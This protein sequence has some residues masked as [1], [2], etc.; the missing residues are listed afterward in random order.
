MSGFVAAPPT[1]ERIGDLFGNAEPAKTLAV[2]DAGVAPES[3][4]E[5]RRVRRDGIQCLAP[6]AA[7]ARDQRTDINGDPIGARL[8][9]LFDRRPGFLSV[10]TREWQ[11]R[12]GPKPRP[13]PHS[14]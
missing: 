5:H 9:R 4:E 7:V 3:S 8:R 10:P 13:P 2:D 12:P 14:H 6:V 1:A 11:G